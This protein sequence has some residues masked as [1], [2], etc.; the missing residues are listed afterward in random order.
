MAGQ[1]IIVVNSHKITA[2]LFGKPCRCTLS[3]MQKLTG[4]HFF[5]WSFQI[6]GR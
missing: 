5:I 3:F 1:P 6:E 4:P 2:D